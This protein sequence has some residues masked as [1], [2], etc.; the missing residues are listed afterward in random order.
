M[1]CNCF[2]LS[3]REPGSLLSL[4][5][6]II[7]LVHPANVLPLLFELVIVFVWIFSQ[8]LDLIVDELAGQRMLLWTR[9]LRVIE[10]HQHQKWQVT[11][12]M[13]V[14]HHPGQTCLNELLVV[15]SVFFSLGF[16]L[17]AA[18][19]LHS[20]A[21]EATRH[22]WSRVIHCLLTFSCVFGTNGLMWICWTR[23]LCNMKDVHWWIIPAFPYAPTSSDT[24]I[25]VFLDL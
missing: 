2:F 22:L 7:C 15:S 6:N 17:T 1:S 20:E 8:I 23:S 16:V 19:L 21:E 14:N 25:G 11:L 5:Y 3:G 24:G 18:L 4:Y 10:V 13:T 12:Q 9:V